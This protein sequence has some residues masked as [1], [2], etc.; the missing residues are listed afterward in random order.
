MKCSVRTSWHFG[1]AVLAMT[2]MLSVSCASAVGWTWTGTAMDNSWTNPVNWGKTSPGDYPKDLGALVTIP[3]GAVITL[4]TGCETPVR[5]LNLASGTATVTATAGST[6]KMQKSISAGDTGI[7][8]GNGTATTE[9]TVLTMAVPITCDSSD[10]SDKWYGGTL[11]YSG[12]IRN[13]SSARNGFGFIFGAGSNVLANAGSVK[14]DYSVL[15][16]SNGNPT[17]QPA[18]L[19]LRDQASVQ[20]YRIWLNAHGVA[21]VHPCEMIQCGADT[22]VTVKDK[23]GNAGELWV[24]RGGAASAE[25]RYVLED[26]SL[27]ANG[28]IVGSTG[29]TIGSSTGVARGSFEQ[30]GGTLTLGSGGITLASANDRFAFKGGKFIARATQTIPAAVEISGSPSFGV[31]SGSRLNFERYPGCEKFV[32]DS[33]GG[34]QMAGDFAP[35]GP[36]EIRGGYFM[37]LAGQQVETSSGV[38]TWRVNVANGTTFVVEDSTCRVTVPFDL[39]VAKGGTLALRAYSAIVAHRMTYDGAE[40]QKGIYQSGIE[41]APACLESGTALGSLIVPFVWTGAGD[42]ESWSDPANWDAKKVPPSSST[43]AVDLSAATNVTLADDTTVGCVI[44]RST[45]QA[46]LTGTGTLTVIAPWNMVPGFIIDQ[47]S[48]LTLDVNLMRD[49]AANMSTIIGGGTLLVKKDFPQYAANSAGE[50]DAPFVCDATVSFGGRTTICTWGSHSSLNFVLRALRANSTDAVRFEDGCS[51]TIDGDLVYNTIGHPMN[52]IVQAGGTV[53]VNGRVFIQS[54]TK[55]KTPDASMS[56]DNVAMRYRMQG[57]TLTVKGS[58]GI[59]L[60]TRYSGSWPHSYGGDLRIEGG[61]VEAPCLK[62]E[63]YSNHLDLVG[64]AFSVGSGGLK[65]V[66]T[67][68]DATQ[69]AVL[70]RYHDNFAVRLGGGT[71]TARA[72]LTCELGIELTGE[73][74]AGVIDTGSYTVTV[75]NAVRGAGGLEKRGSGRLVLSGPTVLAG[76]NTVSAGVLELTGAVSGTLDVLNVASR[77]SLA[78]PAGTVLE[79][80]DLYINGRQKAHDAY[81]D[82]G[83]GKVHVNAGCDPRG[84]MLFIR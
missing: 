8:V 78:L 20:A 69:K 60:G 43:T 11:V 48:R 79:V 21:G 18:K 47:Q 77:N 33:V 64:G 52:E 41:G 5:G 35:T 19:V 38:D 46:T 63:C 25:N 22:Q 58:D 15:G 45:K 2:T 17:D 24:G 4:D 54:T 83:G 49:K 23:D 84:L 56:I 51:A 81:V 57:G 66:S 44:A 36:L 80:G 70:E 9:A 75:T 6:L 3:S 68:T 55:A 10:R 29:M 71:L 67:R 16:L 72:N 37:I 27:T 34:V 53:T 65:L 30:R 28:I 50:W 13:A 42:S 82:F 39:T 1:R 7:T 61:E 32:V 12:T 40:V 14:L 74:G 62:C 31:V 26:G 73:K 59:L 76:T